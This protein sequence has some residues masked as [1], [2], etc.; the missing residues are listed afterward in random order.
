MSLS[1]LGFHAT[2]SIKR[3]IRIGL[4]GIGLVLASPAPSATLNHRTQAEVLQ[5]IQTS[6]P[7]ALAGKQ[8]LPFSE[9][10]QRLSTKRVILVGEIH[11]RYDHHLNQLALLKALH[12]RDPN[13]GIGVEWFQQPFQPVIDAYLAGRIDEPEMLKRSGYYERWRYDYRMLRPILVFAKEHRIPVLALNAPVEV[14]QKVAHGGL[15]AL[16][17]AERAQLPKHINPPESSYLQRLRKV[18]MAHGVRGSNEGHFENF[19]LVQRIWDETMAA[20]A[21]EFLQANPRYRLMIFTGS[22]HISDRM[23]IPNDMARTIP[24]QQIATVATQNAGDESLGQFDYV[25]L[26]TQPHNLIPTGKLGAWFEPDPRGLQV[27]KVSNKGAAAQAGLLAGDRLVK[28]NDQPIKTMTD[29]LA[30]LASFNVG[31]SVKVSIERD[32]LAPK[33]ELNTPVTMTLDIKLL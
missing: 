11:D 12:D 22:G 30:L 5:F 32:R 29:L 6:P 3:L 15:E 4:L 26:S 28:L 17:E 23:G 14:T 2:Y 10:V 31:D 25:V 1:T 9:L 33:G 19:A 8:L 21:V 7:N 20:N 24:A 13:I 16:T 27:T 18:F